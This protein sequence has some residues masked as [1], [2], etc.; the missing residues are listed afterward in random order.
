MVLGVEHITHDTHGN[1]SQ[2]VIVVLVLWPAIWLIFTPGSGAFPYSAIAVTELDQLGTLVTIVV[3]ST[4]RL[5]P[6][7]TQNVPYWR[8]WCRKIRVSDSSDLEFLLVRDSH[9]AMES[10]IRRTIM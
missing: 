3:V 2:G 1:S 6:W 7:I 4:M 5:A 10:P 8:R 9:I